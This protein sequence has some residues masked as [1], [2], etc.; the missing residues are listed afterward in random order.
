MTTS[1]LFSIG[2]LFVAVAVAAACSDDPASSSSSAVATLIAADAA[3]RELLGHSMRHILLLH[4]AD[5]T[6]VMIDPLIRAYQKRGV[7]F[8]S[9]DDA[10]ADPAYQAQPQVVP[11]GNFMW[12]LR[13]ARGTRSRVA[14]PPQDTLLDLVCR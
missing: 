3:A 10:M 7:R 8:I 6:S 12:R 4:A 11:Y 5:F 14:V 1:R 2:A 13:K 9:L